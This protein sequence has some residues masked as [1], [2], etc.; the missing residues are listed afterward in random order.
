MKI[1]GYIFHGTAITGDWSKPVALTSV[2]EFKSKFGTYGP[3]GSQTFEYVSG[4]LSAGLPVL[5]QRIACQ[6]QA[7]VSW[8]NGVPTV[9]SEVQR[10]QCA[11]FTVSHTVTESNVD[12]TVNDLTVS[13]KFGGT[14]GNAMSVN[15][16]VKNKTHWIEIRYNNIVLEKYKIVTMTGDED[17]YTK[18]MKFINAINSIEFARVNVDIDIDITDETA[19]M[20]FVIPDFGEGVFNKLTGG[21]D[22]AEG[23]VAAEIPSLIYADSS[24]SVRPLILDK[25]LY[26]PKFITSGGYTDEDGTNIG[27]AMKNLTEA[28]QD[29]RALIDLPLGLP[30]SNQQTK[31]AE[32]GYAQLSGA[33]IIPSASM[34]APWCYMQVGSAQVWM[35]PSFVY[36]TVVGDALSKGGKVY[37]PK[38]GVSSGRVY[39]VLKPEFAIGSDIAEK[40]QS[41]GQTNINPIMQLQSGDYIIAGNSTLLT[42]DTDEVNAFNESSA[43]LTVIEIRR[44][45]YNLA[46]EL[47]YQYNS[48]TAFEDFSLKASNFLNIM[49][50]NGAVADYAIANISTEDDPRTLKLKVN[51]WVTPTIKAIEINLNIAYGSVTMSTG[52]EA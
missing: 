8:S 5:F 52:G 31:A 2:D 43:D 36:L 10:A 9:P 35:P 26:Q 22:F 30:K 4:V 32:Y 28:R 39:N 13:E 46:E 7:N 18:N 24:A 21:T 37:T 12:T 50:S 33:T 51:V 3:E 11:T 48:V 41:E 47:Q 40:W 44:F 29:C 34:C 38:A 49:V 6:D 19:V 17:V 42:I 25:I 15:F 23:L 1:T 27:A 20:G 16:S 45:M 14:Y